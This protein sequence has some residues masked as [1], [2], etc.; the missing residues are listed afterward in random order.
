[1]ASSAPML[2]PQNQVYREL[3]LD[4]LHPS[5][6][7]PRRHAT[8]EA[9]AELAASISAVGIIEP[10]LARPRAGHATFEVVAGHRRLAAAKVA[11]LAA[12]PVVVRTLSDVEALE[13]AVIEN[14]Q[15][16]DVHPLDEAEAFAHLQQLA[17]YTDKGIAAKIGRPVRYVADRLRL[18]QL[19]AKAK[20]AFEADQI[21]LGHAQLLAKLT[22]A[23]QKDGLRECFEREFSFDGEGHVE[24]LQPVHALQGWINDHVR[25]DLDAPGAQED[26]PE[27]VEEVTR[28]KAEGATVLML[29][30]E[31]Y[32][33][34][35]PSPTDPLLR[36]QWVESKAKN[37]VLGVIVEG[38]RRGKTLKVTLKTEPKRQTMAAAPAKK[39]KPTAAEQE[40]ARK[41]REAEEKRRAEEK[42]RADREEQLHAAVV[43]ALIDEATAAAFTEP[44]VLRVIASAI[45]DC[46]CFGYQTIEVAAKALGV[47][48]EVFALHGDRARLKLPAEKLRAIIAIQVVGYEWA[49]A[50][51]LDAA[52]KAFG[53]DAKALD[54]AL[55][56]EQA[57]AAK[58]STTTKAAKKR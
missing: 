24:V 27:L 38:R 29:S 19:E 5:P 3:A 48:R 34:G 51:G 55:A 7:N 30:D 44:A 33:P 20:A 36:N 10:L 28:A 58:A 35:T 22:P 45:A 12:V 56:K 46:D 43:R 37:A 11:G 4:L 41:A 2:A 18:L 6:S 52:C 16:K 8:P 14:D 32:R 47:S 17:G 39:K 49:V 25:L 15:R 21:S 53:I 31:W 54:K 23:L 42:A 57:A 40:A 1:M 13:I 9:D 50:G 26:F